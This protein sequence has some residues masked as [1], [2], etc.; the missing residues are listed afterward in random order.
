MYGP[1]GLKVL[2][3]AYEALRE[4]KMKGEASLV[5]L[6]DLW[7]HALQE[8]AVL[9]NKPDKLWGRTGP[10]ETKDML[11]QTTIGPWQMTI[12]NVKDIYGP[13]YGV[14]QEWSN[15]EVYRFCRE[16]PRLQA[17]MITDYIQKSYEDYGKHSP[18]AIQRYFWLEAYVK[19]DIGQ[20]LWYKSPVAVSPTGR[21]EDLTP[22]MKRDT[23]FYAKQVL[24]GHPGNKHGLLFWLW[25]TKDYNAIEDALLTWKEQKKRVWED[26]KAVLTDEPGRFAIQPEDIR[27]CQCHP[28]YRD[29]VLA[30]LE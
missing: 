5:Q 13:P 26:G 10:L 19:G 22:E 28:D 27:F 14:K 7:T 6:E 17:K 30:M 9:F 1:G 15:E 18:Y 16:R 11:G 12:W 21:W 4:K 23:G 20:G 3:V 2:K 25:V 8:G 29:F 24:L